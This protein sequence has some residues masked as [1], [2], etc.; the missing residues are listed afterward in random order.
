MPVNLVTNPSFASATTGWTPRGGTLARVA[1]AGVAGV[2]F[3]RVTSTAGATQLSVEASVPLD[4]TERVMSVALSA[5]TTNVASQSLHVVVSF[6]DGGGQTLTPQTSARQTLTTAWKQWAL[7]GVPVPAGAVSMRIEP[8]V[9]SSTGVTY[10]PTATGRTLDVDAVIASTTSAALA[11]FDG[12]SAGA[13][14][15]GAAG[16]STSGLMLGRLQPVPDDPCPRVQIE[17]DALPPTAAFARVT[18]TVDGRGEVVR[19]AV[20]RAIAG[21]LNVT[22]YETPPGTPLTYRAELFNAEGIS[23]GFTLESSTEVPDTAPDDGFFYVWLHNPLDPRTAVRVAWHREA[24]SRIRKSTPGDVRWAQGRRLGLVVAS[25]RTGLVAV[26]LDVVT[27]TTADADRLDALFGDADHDRR[28]I[29]CVR[30]CRGLAITRLPKVWF[31]GIFAQD[32]EPDLS[33]GTQE[34]VWRMQGDQVAPPTPGLVAPLLRRKD[35]DAFYASR[36]AIDQQNA[37]R[38]ALDGRYELAGVGGV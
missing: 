28:P 27:E 7:E 30:I 5:K 32:Y 22:D 6:L 16:L 10:V 31:A 29:V 11:Y 26:P 3:G 2:G 23:L 8:I 14:W 15:Y 13:F 37:S 33:M 17:F 36:Q 25:R 19:D 18:R 35:I 1:S 38:A 34:T 12:D 4:G 21:G 20:N 9:V 24:L